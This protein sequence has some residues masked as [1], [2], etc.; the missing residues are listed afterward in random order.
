MLPSEEA[1]VL[2]THYGIGERPRTMAE[3]AAVLGRSL[4]EARRLNR[5]A[6]RRLRSRALTASD[7]TQWDEV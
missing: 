6:L 2:W 4:T 1:A 7:D 5:R 3:V